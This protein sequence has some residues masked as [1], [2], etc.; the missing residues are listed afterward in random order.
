[1]E[2]ARELIKPYRKMDG[3]VGIYLVGSATRPFRDRDPLSDYDFEVV[4]EDEAFSRVPP[5][6][7]LVFVIEEGPPRRV[8]H[9]FY[10]RPWKELSGLVRSTLDLDHHPYQPRRSSTTRL[11]ARRAH[12]A[13]PRA[14]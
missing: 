13:A 8:D 6:K 7:K 10:L 12:G 1:M 5:D 14:S 9:E 11:S 3:L 2:R 4:M